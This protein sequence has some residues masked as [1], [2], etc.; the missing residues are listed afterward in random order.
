MTL[1]RSPVAMS[2][3]VADASVAK[4]G[5]SPAGKRLPD[6]YNEGARYGGRTDVLLA[7]GGDDELYLPCKTDGRVRKLVAVTISLPPFGN[8]QAITRNR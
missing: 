4:G 5:K 6:P 7:L 1:R 3:I 8:G 2:D